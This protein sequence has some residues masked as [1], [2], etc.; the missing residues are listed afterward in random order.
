MICE[1]CGTKYEYV[2]GPG[3]YRRWCSGT[4]QRWAYNHPGQ[5]RNPPGELH[6]VRSC[7][8]CNQEFHP[9]RGD[10][11]FCM[12]LCADLS[13]GAR[14]YGPKG[15]VITCEVCKQRKAVPPDPGKL[16]KAC[17]ACWASRQY[18]RTRAWRKNNPEAHKAAERRRE[19]KPERLARKAAAVRV[20][21]EMETGICRNPAIR[22]QVYMQAAGVCALCRT[23]V[24]RETM[25]L[26]HIVAIMR[27]GPDTIENLQ[28]AHF[29]CNA[30]KGA[31]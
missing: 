22:T 12:T 15:Y 10:S 29:S 16:R 28:L 7:E 24:P 2:A 18:V 1:A 5:R 8:N 9:K 13:R 30:R 23:V 6:P 3:R 21:R 11:R 14:V 31:N 17:L 4:C 25:T 19:S 26:D 20:R 27:G